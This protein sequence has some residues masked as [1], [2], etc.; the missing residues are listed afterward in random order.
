MRLTK[1]EICGAIIILAVV[2]AVIV[3]NIREGSLRDQELQLEYPIL[4]KEITIKEKVL[5]KYNFIENGFRDLAV[6]SRLQVGNDKFGVVAE[7]DKGAGSFGINE[8]VEVGDS[9]F[10]AADSD[11]ILIKKHNS[12][13]VYSFLRRDDNY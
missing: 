6:F 11:T 8:I 7:E 12:I 5:F 9:L 13:E 1:G 10:K 4:Q 3:Y 2:V